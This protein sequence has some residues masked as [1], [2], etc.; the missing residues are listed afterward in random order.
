M[1]R[2][3]FSTYSVFDCWALGVVALAV[4]FSVKENEYA[5]DEAETVPLPVVEQVIAVEELEH[6]MPTGTPLG[7]GREVAG[8]KV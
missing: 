1:V 5:P 6:T 2:V 8:G 7:R 3:L 4:S